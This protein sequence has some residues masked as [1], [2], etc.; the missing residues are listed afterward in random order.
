MYKLTI[1]MLSLPHRLSFLNKLVNE[2][3]NQSKGLPVEILYFGDSRSYPIG[4]K[5]NIL[6]QYAQGEYSCW[7]D[8]DDFIPNYYINE[9][10]KVI[11]YKPDV[12][13]WT[14][15]VTVNGEKMTPHPA[16]TH[17]HF[18]IKYNPEINDRKNKIFYHR[19]CHINP[20]KHKIA[21]QFP[22]KECSYC[23]ADLDRAKDMV[24]IL[25]TEYIIPKVMYFHRYGFFN[26]KAK[27]PK[28]GRTN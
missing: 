26:D 11:E 7:I 17:C 13:C 27:A 14:N 18:S 3:E 5:R 8:D 16:V 2:L 20:V 21:L 12:I 19:P 28:T 15:Q 22:F 9:I 6:Q 25:K 10:L 4:Q 24:N 23:R 1:M